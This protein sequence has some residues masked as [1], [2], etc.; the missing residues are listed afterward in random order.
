MDKKAINK[1]VKAVL[2]KYEG[3]GLNLYL[4]EQVI[5]SLEHGDDVSKELIESMILEELNKEFLKK[6]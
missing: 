6:D 1:V 4:L 2:K 3:V 5:D